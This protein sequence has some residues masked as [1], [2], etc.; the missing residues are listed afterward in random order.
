[1]ADWLEDGMPRDGEPGHGDLTVLR[2]L[3]ADQRDKHARKRDRNAD[4]RDAEGD[5]RDVVGEQRDI[6]GEL[7][8]LSADER[9]LE[10][11]RL[12]VDADARDERERNSESRH[13]T[14]AASSTGN[15]AE[16]IR[17]SSLRREHAAADRRRAMRDRGQAAVERGEARLDRGAALANRVA[18]AS[19]RESAGS[20][21]DTAS[22]DRAAAADD[23]LVAQL[24]ERFRELANN[25]DAGFIL[26]A[27]E[28]PEFLYL[29]PAFSVIFGFDPAG[30]PPAPADLL[31][32]VHLNDRARVATALTGTV[33]GGP[34]QQEFRFIRPDGM[35][36]WAWERVSPIT[37]DDGVIRRVA[38][39]F[40]DIT[41]RKSA[42]AALHQSEERLDQLA[43][44]TEVGFFV[45]ESSKM[46]YMNAGLFRILALDPAM[47][48]PTMPDIVSMIHP[49]DQAL[50]AT[51]TEGADRD[52]STQVEL[53]IIRPDGAIRWIRQTNDPVT[54]TAGDPIRVAGTITDVTERK[55][56]EEIAR[57]AQLD[58]QRANTAKDEFLSRISHELRTPLNAVIG[59]A[60]LLELDEL[61][62]SQDE[63][64]GHILHGGRHLL[65]MI[66]DVLDIAV[67]GSDRIELAFEPIDTWELVRDTIGLMRPL[68]AARGIEINLVAGPEVTHCFVLA[69]RRRLKQ[70][71]LNLLS[72]AIKYNRPAGRIDITLALDDG[73]K[74]TVAVADT[75]FG[76]DPEDLPRL[77]QPFDRLHQSSDI[78]GTGLGL[79]LSERLTS[80]MN[81]RLD[82]QSTHGR[83]STFSVTLPM[84]EPPLQD[85]ASTIDSTGQSPLPTA[86]SS[87]LYIEDTS[88]N[89][90]LLIGIL[91]RRPDWTMTHAGTGVRGLE[92]AT[93]IE[94]TVILLDLHLPDIKGLEVIT[95][96]R[97]NPL[98]A[99]IPVAILSA[100]ATRA[101]VSRMF[102][103][104]AQK[105]FTK[106]IN[107]AEV[108]AFLDSH[109]R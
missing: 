72:N 100:D 33:I 41:D 18:G 31:S 77:F 87:V 52:E 85:G 4:A 108:Y 66:N 12:D 3:N 55:L 102:D 36:R 5:Q 62:P 32:L 73:T 75:G 34:F 96:L 27:I 50:S 71:L 59:F 40:S 37:D 89:V 51:A 95:A 22:D 105:Y 99:A 107:V 79:A 45:R 106:P 47:P 91:R 49:D 44:S 58:A 90:D 69:D 81:G 61:T 10:S 25:V 23:R 88:S 57:S 54:T 78:E 30:A 64:V 6:D 26:R 67:I 56:A 13:G 83:G 63:A 101:Q 9:D 39:I 93:A 65:A 43:R 1:M 29:N 42:E 8:D 92:L 82:A 15:G 17:L 35:E 104:G 84:A 14:D 46:L 16:A 109:A 20:D 2:D 53:R 19:G 28:P 24:E 70:V 94:P 80:L 74:L 68:A 76:I 21:R 97:G 86:L 48:N 11:L 103:A 60:Q 38:G 7:R 98:T